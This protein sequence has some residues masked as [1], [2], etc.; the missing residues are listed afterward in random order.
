MHLPRFSTLPSLSFKAVSRLI[1]YFTYILYNL[2]KNGVLSWY[3]EGCTGGPCFA[4]LPREASYSR[5]MQ[6]QLS[7]LLA[8]SNEHLSMTIITQHQHF[9]SV[10]M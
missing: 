2:P 6:V 10:K 4:L 5:W 9:L 3:F 7:A 1:L 8:L